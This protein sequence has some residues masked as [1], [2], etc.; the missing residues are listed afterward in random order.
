MK[1]F[2][3]NYLFIGAHYGF[4]RGRS[5]TSVLLSLVSVKTNAFESRES[6]M[7]NLCD[8]NLSK[9]FDVVSHDILIS[10]LK[11]YGINRAVL[12]GVEDYLADRQ[13]LVS[14][15][16]ASFTLSSIMINNLSL[17]GQTIL[18]AD[19]TTLLIRVRDLLQLRAEADHLLQQ[20]T[21]AAPFKN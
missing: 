15:K 17:S 21:G 9:A 5:T 19:N 7:I 18:F 2:E 11:R 12:Q 6:V 4:R 20:S 16:G 1:F 13:Q 8:L 3:E 14:L 10:K